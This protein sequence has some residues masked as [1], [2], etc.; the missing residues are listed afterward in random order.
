MAPQIVV[1]VG[2]HKAGILCFHFY[3]FYS[4]KS[5]HIYYYSLTALIKETCLYFF[6]ASEKV[7]AE[8]R[9][10]EG[11]NLTEKINIFAQY[12]LQLW[13]NKNTVKLQTQLIKGKLENIAVFHYQG[14]LQFISSIQRGARKG[15]RM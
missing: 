10:I 11:P 15:V 8:A 6:C 13:Y 4:V 12:H 14:I 5:Q 9:F 1:W 3:I 7:W 2:L